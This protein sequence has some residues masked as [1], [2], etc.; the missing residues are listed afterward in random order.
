MNITHSVFFQKI[1]LIQNITFLH[2]IALNRKKKGLSRNV[3]IND[4]VNIPVAYLPNKLVGPAHFY[5]VWSDFWVHVQGRGRMMWFPCILMAQPCFIHDRFNRLSWIVYQKVYCIA[6]Q[7]PNQC[8][9]E[10]M[11]KVH[12]QESPQLISLGFLC[13]KRLIALWLILNNSVWIQKFW[14]KKIFMNSMF[15]IMKYVAQL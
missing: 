15:P 13:Q 5:R 10:Y 11:Y 9:T 14:V 6:R 4:I 8:S 1:Y 3:E 12:H 7:K 2:S